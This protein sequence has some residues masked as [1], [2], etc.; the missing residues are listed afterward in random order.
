MKHNPRSKFC[1][2]YDCTFGA[3]KKTAE[4]VHSSALVGR[5]C[6]TQD[7]EERKRWVLVVNREDETMGTEYRC[8]KDS[9]EGAIHEARILRD[10]LT[11]RKVVATV[12]VGEVVERMTIIE[13]LKT[14]TP[15]DVST[16]KPT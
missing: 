7:A 2:C 16:T 5:A 3:E 13:Q 9:A 8:S 14:S 15:N 10:V 4:A 12:T 1:E 6:V 11:K